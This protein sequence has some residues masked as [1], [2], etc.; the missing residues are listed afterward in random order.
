MRRLTEKNTREAGISDTKIGYWKSVRRN[1]ESEN[2]IL[3]TGSGRIKVNF[4]VWNVARTIL[5]AFNS[6]TGIRRR[7]VLL[8]AM[9]FCVVQV[10]RH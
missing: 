9:L 4:A 10:S 2:K 7:R 6:I 5:H 8:L 1:G 3:E